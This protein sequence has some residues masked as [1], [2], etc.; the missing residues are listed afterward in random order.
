MTSFRY[1]AGSCDICV[2]ATGRTLPRSDNSPVAAN[3]GTIAGTAYWSGGPVL[4]Y[5]LK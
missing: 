1:F 3:A 2:F 5:V 4:L